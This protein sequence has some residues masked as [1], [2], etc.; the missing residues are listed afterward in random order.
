M[1]YSGSVPPYNDD[2]FSLVNCSYL[3]SFRIGNTEMINRS[4]DNNNAVCPINIL[5]NTIFHR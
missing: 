3:T 4:G 1:F 2:E 5:H